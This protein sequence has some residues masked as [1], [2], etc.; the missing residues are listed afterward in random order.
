M[1]R[2]ISYFVTLLVVGAAGFVIWTSYQQ[3]L[4]R[5]WT[6]DGQVRAN[7]VGIAP[8]VAGPISRVLVYD[9]EPVKAGDLLFEIDPADFQANVDNAKAQL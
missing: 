8:R 1:K 7:V 2:P 4:A 3:Y 9:N 5:P 6:R